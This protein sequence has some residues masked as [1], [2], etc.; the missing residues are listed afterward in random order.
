MN[1]ADDEQMPNEKEAPTETTQKKQLS[2][3]QT[4]KSVLWAMLGIQSKENLMRDFTHGKASNF[5]IT[6]L[7]FVILFVLTLILIVNTV[8][9]FA[10]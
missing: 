5:I 9:H 3:F 4:F 7:V 6:G 10:L 2:L 8:L 1:S